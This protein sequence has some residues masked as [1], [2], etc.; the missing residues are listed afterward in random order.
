M[1]VRSVQGR[2]GDEPVDR[3]GLPAA[4][5]PQQTQGMLLWEMGSVLSWFLGKVLLVFPLI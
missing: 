4:Q 1:D 2:P 5:H 3:G